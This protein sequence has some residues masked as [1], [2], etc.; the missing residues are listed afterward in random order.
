MLQSYT[1]KDPLVFV[2]SPAESPASL[3]PPAEILL[4]LSCPQQR[5]PENLHRP[6]QK[7]NKIQRHV[8]VIF[9]AQILNLFF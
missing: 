7:K 9:L 8:F 1:S 5:I 4:L 6:H 3:M 2:M